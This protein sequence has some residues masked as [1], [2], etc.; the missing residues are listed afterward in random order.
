MRHLRIEERGRSRHLYCRLGTAARPVTMMCDLR[1]RIAVER[2]ETGNSPTDAMGAVMVAKCSNPS[3]S[4]SFRY[5]KGG[6]LFRLERNPTL[7]SSNVRTAEYFW[8]CRCCSST[9]TL[10][11]S[12][13]G[14]V[15]PVTLP[16]LVHHSGDFTSAHRQRG[17]L[18]SD[19]T[20][21]IER[22]RGGGGFVG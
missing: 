16:E 7:R 21:S 22:H 17:L 11:L 1:H 4:A 2:E 12:E 5:L 13:D 15:I 19:V 3:C 8:L 6:R 14:S 10:R 9:M 18:L 20:F